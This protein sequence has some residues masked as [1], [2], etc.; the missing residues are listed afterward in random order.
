MF[1]DVHGNLPAFE[2]MLKHAGPCDEYICLGDLVNYGPWSNECVDLA[3]S[4][5]SCR[6]IMGN[7][8]EAFIKGKYEGENTLVKTFFSRCS[9]GFTRIEQIA[10]FK[11][12][13]EDFGFFFQHTIGGQSI[14][15]DTNIQLDANYVIGHSHHQFV[16][17]NSGF[18]LYNTGS[19]GQNRKYGNIVN[20]II[21]DTSTMTFNLL[22]VPYNMSLLISGLRDRDFPPECVDYYLSK[23]LA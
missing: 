18:T 4:L 12:S 8:E 10:S 23:E 1:S 15:P 19:V 13:F 17:N 16:Y 2:T 6:Y 22:A 3:L 21:L 20:Y 7:H 14:Y 5:P 9:P 11:E